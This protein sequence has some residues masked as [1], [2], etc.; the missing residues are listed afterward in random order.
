MEN[1]SNDQNT[2]LHLVQMGKGHKKRCLTHIHPDVIN[3]TL[4]GKELTMKN[5]TMCGKEKQIELVNLFPGFIKCIRTPNESVQLAAVTQDPRSIQWIQNPTGLVKYTAMRCI[6]VGSY[7]SDD[8]YGIKDLIKDNPVIARYL[9]NQS[10]EIQRIVINSPKFDI[11]YITN[12]HPK[13]LKEAYVKTK[14]QSLLSYIKCTVLSVEDQVAIVKISPFNIHYILNPAPETQVAAV[15]INTAVLFYIEDPTTHV[16]CMAVKKDKNAIFA[17]KNPS[18][19]VKELYLKTYPKEK[20]PPSI[21]RQSALIDSQLLV[22]KYINT[23]DIKL[24][25]IFLTKYPQA[26]YFID[27]AP[28]SLQLKVINTD[29][30]MIGFIKEPT[31]TVQTRAVNTN[32]YTIGLINKP[33]KEVQYMIMSKIPLKFITHPHSISIMLDAYPNR[34]KEL[35]NPSYENQEIVVKRIPYALNL[36]DNPCEKI[37][38]IAVR[39]FPEAIKYIPNPSEEVQMTALQNYKYVF[40]I[41]NNPS[42]KAIAFYEKHR[43][44]PIFKNVTCERIEYIEQSNKKR[45]V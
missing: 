1:S 4:D 45:K 42:S 10:L 14:N 18:T 21:P 6:D 34:I 43:N 27:D 24:Q 19:T 22:F 17:I 12:Y 38:L 7:I 16:Q 37:Q 13:A 39:N 5:I 8:L 9:K 41:I 20:Y 25:K 28:P 15:E 11:Q 23:L 31:L 32:S 33:F 40:N 35:T 29:P 2:S 44:N 36:I 30:F 3:M 26:I